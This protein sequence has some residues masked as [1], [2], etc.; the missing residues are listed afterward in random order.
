M[1]RKRL[2]KERNLDW[3]LLSLSR[4]LPDFLHDFCLFD[5]DR[6]VQI[7]VIIVNP[8]SFMVTL[9]EKKKEEKKKKRK[10]QSEDLVCEK[11]ATQSWG[12]TMMKDEKRKGERKEGESWG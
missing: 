3:F 4:P 9:K 2:R 1:K 10:N 11:K 8:I 5:F 12:S 6:H 7:C